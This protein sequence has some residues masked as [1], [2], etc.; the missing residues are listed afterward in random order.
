MF[1]RVDGVMEIMM[2]EFISKFKLFYDIINFKV[3]ICGRN[4]R[5]NVVKNVFIFF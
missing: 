3:L 4:Y 1:V 5:L 2:I